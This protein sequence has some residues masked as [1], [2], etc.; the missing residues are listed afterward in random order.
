MLQAS[1]LDYT[2]VHKIH[3]HMKPQLNKRLLPFCVALIS[4]LI[5]S[6]SKTNVT[7]QRTSEEVQLSARS[8]NEITTYYGPEVQLGNGKIRSVSVLEK[9][10]NKP[11]S[12][13]FELT[14]GALSGLPEDSH[15]EEGHHE[16]SHYLIPLHPTAKANTIFDHLVADWNPHGHPPGP[17]LS[18]HFDFHFYMLPLAQRLQITATDPLSVAPLATGYLPNDYIGPLGPE[19]QM[20]GHCVDVTSPELNGSPFTHTFIYGAYN[21]KVAFYEPMVTHNYLTTSSGGTFNIKQPFYFSKTG[22]Y[23]TKYSIRKDINGKVSIMLSDFV[24]RIAS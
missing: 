20:G 11:L 18:S 13:A 23:P 2:C 14:E 10:S 6:C 8:G 21:S 24:F 3:C 19:P 16:E 7:E 17:Y 22:Y 12:I 9:N 1:Q 4:V 5:L 15:D